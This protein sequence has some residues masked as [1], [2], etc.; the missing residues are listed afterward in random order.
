MKT[1]SRS[2][3]AATPEE[4]PLHG[5]ELLEWGVRVA[6]SSMAGWQERWGQVKDAE[7]DDYQVLE[8]IRYEM[9]TCGGH[10]RPGRPM[11]SYWGGSSPRVQVGEET[12]QGPRLLT[13]VRKIFSIPKPGDNQQGRLF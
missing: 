7:T 3:P 8:R 2:E 6:C 13:I 5:G 10:S 12:I 11:V 9:G 1:T 4:S